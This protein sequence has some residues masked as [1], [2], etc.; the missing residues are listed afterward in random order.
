MNLYKM[1]LQTFCPINIPG[2]REQVVSVLASVLEGKTFCQ[3]SCQTFC[4]HTC[5]FHPIPT[6][7]RE[8]NDSIL[9][10]STTTTLAS[11]FTV[12]KI[13]CCDADPVLSLIFAMLRRAYRVMACSTIMVSQR[14]WHSQTRFSMLFFKPPQKKQ[15][16]N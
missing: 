1:Q 7:L 4:P 12:S 9:L 10:H 2:W 13:C 15:L 5:P 3:T 14:R 6:T 8:S 11:L 16:Y